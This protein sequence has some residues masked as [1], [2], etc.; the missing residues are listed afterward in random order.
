MKD[1]GV[2]RRK[3]RTSVE[4]EREEL[5]ARENDAKKPKLAEATPEMTESGKGDGYHGTAEQIGKT[6]TRRG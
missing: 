2:K 4:A 6:R 1:Q 3:Q 5:M